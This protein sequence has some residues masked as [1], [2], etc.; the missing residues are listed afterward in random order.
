MLAALIR[1]P[2]ASALA[3]AL[4]SALFADDALLLLGRAQLSEINAAGKYAL[5][6]SELAALPRLKSL[7]KNQDGE[8]LIRAAL[9]DSELVSVSDECVERPLAQDLVQYASRLPIFH[10]HSDAH[11]VRFV[12]RGREW[13]FVA[14]PADEHDNAV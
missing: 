13:E 9:E 2:A 8:A 1:A 5:P 14:E 12:W 4:Q 6:L 3:L 11:T 7:L 10:P